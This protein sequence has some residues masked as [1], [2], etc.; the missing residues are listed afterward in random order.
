M[1]SMKYIYIN[2][3]I[4]YSSI[5]CI[6]DILYLLFIYI[7]KLSHTRSKRWLYNLS[8]NGNHFD[9]P[10]YNMTST[11]GKTSAA[12]KPMLTCRSNPRRNNSTINH[13]ALSYL[14]KG[15]LYFLHSL[16]QISNSILLFTTQAH[17]AIVIPCIMT[18][19][20]IRSSIKT[21]NDH[22][23]KDHMD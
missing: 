14:Q 16:Y 4:K 15:I 8:T 6:T 21:E 3:Y 17:Y 2:I 5:F 23:I 13:T 19:M 22:D 18:C 20:S 7:D 1:C 10:I 12:R 9:W 11:Q